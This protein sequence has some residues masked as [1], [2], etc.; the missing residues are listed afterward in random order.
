[1]KYF[2]LGQQR[3]LFVLALF[4]LGI[5]TFNFYYSP[6]A[7]SEEI[8]KEIVIEVIGEV[9]NPGVYI[10]QHSPTLKEAIGKAGGL[11]ESASI[12]PEL[13]SIALETGTL[14][15]VEKESPSN[16]IPSPLEGEGKGEGGL[17]RAPKGIKQDEIKIKI[18]TMEAHK[19]LVF[20]IPLDLN[21]VSMEDLC[22][23]PGIGESLAH[24][25]VTYR[26]RRR[27][28]RSVEEL[29][30][31]KGIGDKKYQSLKNFLIVGS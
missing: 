16:N 7:P 19:L 29:K 27:G 13:S 14:L 28:F 4:L 18:G 21:R 5:L 6:P 23:L 12:D 31:V 24:E 22:L 3:I 25:I 17:K 9:R 1:M 10:F 2:S 11:R 15:T 8:T 26:E 20:S 30:N